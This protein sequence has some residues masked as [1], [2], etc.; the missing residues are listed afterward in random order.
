M[1]L[2]LIF[3][4]PIQPYFNEQ[5]LYRG[6]STSGLVFRKLWLVSCAISQFRESEIEISFDHL[7]RLSCSCK[8]LPSFPKLYFNRSWQETSSSP[9][10]LINIRIAQASHFWSLLLPQTTIRLWVASNDWRQA[11]PIRV[12][13]KPVVRAAWRLHVRPTHL[14]RCEI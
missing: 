3:W 5:H 7:L 4:L 8:Y 14:C 1:E 11:L 12:T 9:Y 13:I 2:T 6:T 10:F